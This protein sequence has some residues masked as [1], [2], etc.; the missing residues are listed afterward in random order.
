MDSSSMDV[1]IWWDRFR[2]VYSQDHRHGYCRTEHKGPVYHGCPALW[3]RQRLRIAH[4]F[5]SRFPIQGLQSTPLPLFKQLACLWQCLG[6][7]GGGK[8][9]VVTNLMHVTLRKM[10]HQPVDEGKNRKLSALVRASFVVVL[11]QKAYIPVVVFDYSSL[12][13]HR[14]LG[15]ATRIAYRSI[16]FSQRRSKSNVPVVRSDKPKALLN[17]E[18]TRRVGT[19]RT[20]IQRRFSVSSADTFDHVKFPFHGQQ[21]SGN[22]IALGRV[23]P[24]FPVKTNAPAGNDDMKMNVP[25]QVTSEGVEHHQKSGS[26][27]RHSPASLTPPPGL[28]SFG[29]RRSHCQTQYRIGYGS[30]QYRYQNIAIVLDYQSQLPRQGEYQMPVFHIQ[31]FREKIAAP[32]L[33]SS[34]AATGA[35]H[36]LAAMRHDL[37]RQAPRTPKQMNSQRYRSAQQHL[38]H[39]HK[40]CRTNSSPLPGNVPPPVALMSQNVR[41]PDLA[42]PRRSHESKYSISRLPSFDLSLY[43]KRR[44][45][46]PI[47]NKERFRTSRNDSQDNRSI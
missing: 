27:A 5:A 1:Q 15:V 40:D 13:N 36:G 47:C 42:L 18:S 25:F 31:H 26:H 45:E 43:A 16:G 46:V 33:G 3:A 34:H 24:P 28:T 7:H 6:T 44:H 30:K 14:T 39:I 41:N 19:Q 4:C 20:T 11:E 8:Q 12:C 2:S 23:N 10:L 38:T 9:P 21:W 35:Q 29:L 37:H 17:V 32:A 22:H